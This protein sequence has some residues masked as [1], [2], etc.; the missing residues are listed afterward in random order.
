MTSQTEA[1]SSDQMDDLSSSNDSDTTDQYAADNGID[2]ATVIEPYFRPD[3]NTIVCG[4]LDDQKISALAEAGVELVINLQP[5]DELSFDEA[6]AVERAGM[7]YQHLPISG[8][9]DLKQLKILAFDNLLRQYHGKKIVMH[10]M[11]G[12]RVGAAAALRAGW[13]RGRKMDTAME[14]GRSHGL[15]KLEQEVHNRLLVPR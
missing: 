5:T 11:S 4:A 14:R 10:C 15:T 6:A 7:H 2:L 1:V 3:A 9:A 13:L 8:A 12:N